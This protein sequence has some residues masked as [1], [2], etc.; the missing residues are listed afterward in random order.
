MPTDGDNE[1]EPSVSK[2]DETGE[3]RRLRRA[4]LED[5]DDTVVTSVDFQPKMTDRATFLQRQDNEEKDFDPDDVESRM[6]AEKSSLKSSLKV[7]VSHF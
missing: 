1:G 5:E 2:I 4:S 7:E 6:P 3:M